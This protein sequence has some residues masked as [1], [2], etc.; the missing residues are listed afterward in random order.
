MLTQTLVPLC[1]ALTQIL[2][3]TLI[4]THSVHSSSPDIPF[5]SAMPSPIGRLP[6]TLASLTAQPPPNPAA[7]LWGLRV[8]SPHFLRSE[9]RGSRDWPGELALAPNGQL[10]DLT[11]VVLMALDSTGLAS[12]WCLPI[13]GRMH[14][15]EGRP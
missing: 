3:I 8:W 12:V 2:R 7:F 9:G 4:S 6:R 11:S 1:M 13:A 10:L 14:G 15:S 5:P